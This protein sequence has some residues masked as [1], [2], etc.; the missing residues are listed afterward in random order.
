MGILQILQFPSCFQVSQTKFPTFLPSFEEKSFPPVFEF[1]MIYQKFLMLCALTVCALS[2]HSGPGWDS[3]R[4]KPSVA[5]PGRLALNPEPEGVPQ[6][7]ASPRPSAPQKPA[8]PKAQN[9]TDLPPYYPLGWEERI[10]ASSGRKY[11]MNKYTKT[12]TWKNPNP[13]EEPEPVSAPQKPASPKSKAQQTPPGPP[14]LSGDIGLPSGWGSTL[15]ASGRRIYYKESDPLT[16]ATWDHPS[17]PKPPATMPSSTAWL[18]KIGS[19]DDDDDRRQT[20]K[21]YN[22]G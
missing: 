12:T 9:S 6:K 21:R 1:T 3:P 2:A 10:D 13:L 15:N 18:S 14:G 8:S 11:Y 5:Y 4:R 19:Y 17:D 16:S 20:L 22:S 7:P